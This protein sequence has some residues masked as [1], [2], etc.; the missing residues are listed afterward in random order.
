MCT[1][2]SRY[3]CKFAEFEFIYKESIIRYMYI[4]KNFH[5]YEE[6]QSVSVR[7]RT[8]MCEFAQLGLIYK[9]IY[10]MIHVYL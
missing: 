9:S 8:N 1:G 2:N 6:V 10:S 3:I 7:Q 5:V 4:C